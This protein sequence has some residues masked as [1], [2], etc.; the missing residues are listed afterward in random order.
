MAID[1]KLSE[2]ACF[3]NVFSHPHGDR[4]EGVFKCLHSSFRIVLFMGSTNAV[5]V[6]TDSQNATKDLRFHAKTSKTHPNF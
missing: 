1:S 4:D 6:Q 5:L 2:Q 3:L